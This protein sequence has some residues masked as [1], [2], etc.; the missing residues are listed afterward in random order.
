MA[1]GRCKMSSQSDEK[2]R[3]LARKVA[4][5]GLYDS[6]LVEGVFKKTI[7]E[8]LADDLEQIQYRNSLKG[9][10]KDLGIFAGVATGIAFSILAAI[11]A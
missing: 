7:E 2:L 10:L 6:A 9:K 3:L 11:L 4:D 1:N 8:N 5:S